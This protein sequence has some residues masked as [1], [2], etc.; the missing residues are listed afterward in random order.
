V[1]SEK[2]DKEMQGLP[3]SR[4]CVD[5]Y[6]DRIINSTMES[7]MTSPI[8]NCT[9][10]SGAHFA[11][12]LFAFALAGPALAAPLFAARFDI[13]TSGAG[14]VMLLGSIALLVIAVVAKIVGD[15]PYG[16][17]PPTGPDLRWWKR[18][19]PDAQP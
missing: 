5:A 4:G 10:R 3:L 7:N 6:I 17:P 18:P 11:G 8:S 1:A 12:G 9:S 19:P 14:D 15:H 13:T 16:E 2:S